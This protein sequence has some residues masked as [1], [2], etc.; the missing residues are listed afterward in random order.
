MRPASINRGLP[1]FLLFLL[2]VNA[3]PSGERQDDGVPEID[4]NVP[5]L[6]ATAGGLREAAGK[7]GLPNPVQSRNIGTKE[8][9]NLHV[10]EIKREA[11][12]EYIES[13]TPD[14]DPQ[15]RAPDIEPT[16]KRNFEPRDIEEREVGINH[17]EKRE[18]AAYTEGGAKK[19]KRS[20]ESQEMKA[21]LRARAEVEREKEEYESAKRKREERMLHNKKFK[22]KM[23]RLFQHGSPFQEYHNTVPVSAYAADDGSFGHSLPGA[24]R[25]PLDDAGE[26]G[27]RSFTERE[28]RV[29]KARLQELGYAP[30]G[31]DNFDPTAELA[32][33]RKRAEAPGLDVTPWNRSPLGKRDISHHIACP[34][35]GLMSSF[36]NILINPYTYF[37]T[38]AIFRTACFGCDC[39]ANINGFYLSYRTEGGCSMRLTENCQMAGCRC[40]NTWSSSDPLL[41]SKPDW[42]AGT[43][44]SPATYSDSTY[45]PQTKTTYSD[46]YAA[47]AHVNGEVTF[48]GYGKAKRNLQS[49]NLSHVGELFPPSKR[50][51]LDH[52]E[53]E[54]SVSRT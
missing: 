15:S 2:A 53:Y 26:L 4:P 6:T 7:D 29:I 9:T 25:S 17:Q 3:F 33:L 31:G 47:A 20:S 51:A 12:A 5:K 8:A 40:L 54:E 14:P 23:K 37:A 46:K 21:K 41:V 10:F 22:L 27:K 19:V 49:P 48:G 18:E 39:S 28:R 35:T 50:D 44:W 45:N 43:R 42:Q 24:R 13:L 11:I 36:G 1:S 16:E 32:K 38:I 52:I 30:E 34:S